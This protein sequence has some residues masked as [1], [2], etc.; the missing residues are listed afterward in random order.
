MLILMVAASVFGSLHGN[1]SR[2]IS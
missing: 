2:S 1:S